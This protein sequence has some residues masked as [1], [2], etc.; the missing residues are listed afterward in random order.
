MKKFLLT[1]VW[2]LLFFSTAF[3]QIVYEDFEGTPLEWNPFGDGVFNGVIDN[4]DPNFV[5]NSAKAGSYTK[6]DM[7]AYSLLIAILPNPMDLS[8]MNQ[9]SIDIYSPVATQVLLKLEGDGEA[10]EATKN[11]ANT[12]VWQR[13]TFDF[14]AAANFTTITK[15]IV[16]F[17]PGVENSGD[18]YLFDNIIAN[19][20]GPCAGTL[21]DPLLIDDYECQRNATYGSGWDILTPV[22][23]PDPT[24]INTS[25][26]VGQYEDPTDEWSALVI[27]Y[28]NPL[29][30]SVNNHIKAKIWAPKTGQ[31][32][33]KLEG[34]IS[35]P[36]EIFMDVVQTNTWVEY[37]AD[38]STQANADHKRIAIFF[39]AGVLAEPN[40]IYYIDDIS[41]AQGTP[42][43]ALEDFENGA[44]LP[45]QPLNGDMLNHGTFDG[46]IAN[47]D[48]SAINDSP[49][50]G[51]YTKGDAAFS[52]LTSFLPNGLDLSSKPQLNLQVRA[53][54][55]SQNVTLQLV[56]AT[57]GNK[58]VTRD[59]PAVMEWTQL[60]FN[61]EE[62]SSIT[63]FERINILFDPGVAAP[64]TSY[65][66]DNLEQGATTVDPCEGVLP[67][68]TILDDYECQRNVAYGAGADRLSVENNPDVSPENPSASA[69]QYQDP[70]DEWSALGF[71]SGGSWDL[72]VFNQFSIKI[73]SPLAVPLLFKLEGGTSPAVEIWTEVTQP[74]KWV[75]Y[76]VDF[77]DHAGEDHARI[78]VFFNAGQLPAQEDLYYIDDVQWKRIN[79]SGCV[80]DNETFNSTIANFQYFANGHIEAEDNKLKIVDNPNPSGINDSEKVGQFTKA[81]DG[82]VFAGAFAA[83]GAPIEFGD[84][85]TMRAKVLMDHIGNF[86]MKVEASATGADPIEIAVPNTLTNEWEELTFDFSAAPD[87]AQYQT[88][89]IFFDLGMDPATDDVTSYFDDFV[90]GNGSCPFGPTAVFQPFR[91]GTF[92]LSPNPVREVLLIEN[93]GGVVQLKVYDLYGRQVGSL[94]SDGSSPARLSVTDFPQGL[95]LLAGFDHNGQLVANAKF[96]RE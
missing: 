24:G 87:N 34:G 86:A 83:L 2:P 92:L 88:L 57:Q 60:E 41:F 56:S 61:F 44:N 65:M 8:V 18:T 6:S 62:F 20:A 55:G 84:N 16:F 29:D 82:A 23:N 32:L 46:V 76:T 13:Y 12:N 33:F 94:R 89:T 90:I 36:A 85:K 59:L 91:V 19:P 40:D 30:L 79:Y 64:G 67:V 53:P 11:I 48:P 70:L 21:P 68:P 80:N 27:D 51:R 25:P 9:F 43:N 35:P 78:V 1:L 10:I 7:H 26:T 58:E 74:E 49:N 95:Y 93:P 63:D 69:G 28:H 22:P 72:T 38:F 54:G 45:W 75:D 52:T 50:A 66:F 37:S 14:S 71:E 5:N 4:P 96:V 77:S 47:P 81:N 42:A 15:I 17:D 3:S 73:W 31:V 39:N